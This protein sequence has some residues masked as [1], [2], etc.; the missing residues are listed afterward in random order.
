MN[1]SS[2]SADKLLTTLRSLPP[3]ELYYIAYS[4]G[5]DSHVLLHALLSIKSELNADIHALHV[6]HG[7]N[8]SANSWATHCEKTCNDLEINFTLLKIDESCPRGESR[9]A[10]ARRLRYQLLIARMSAGDVLLTAHHQD[11][12][13]ETLL[14]QMS[15]GAG[16]KGL[17][18]M[19]MLKKQDSVWHARP[20]LG[21]GRQHLMDYARLH[22]LQWIEDD[23][24]SDTSYDR[25][26]FRKEII[27]KLQQR[28]PSVTATLARAASHQVEAMMLLEE[29]AAADLLGCGDEAA[30]RLKLGPLLLLSPARQANVIRYWLRSLKLPVPDSRVMQEILNKFL[31][32]RADASPLISWPGIE[33]RR[34]QQHLYACGPLRSH[35]GQNNLN[36]HLESPCRCSD[37]VL[38]A[39]MG[40]G[41]GI[42]VSVCPDKQ[43]QVGYRQGGEKIRLT[44]K[45]ST[46]E[47]KKLFQ[48]A[49]IPPWLRDRVPLLYKDDVLIA[50]AGLWIAAE[51]CTGKDESAWQIHWTGLDSLKVSMQYLHDD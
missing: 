44:K 11:D 34:Y 8:V 43:L 45:G 23:S 29:M 4:G 20:L 12:Q 7:L 15:R 19:P 49:G 48:Q 1:D 14:L 40:Q 2:F 41:A 10:W 37:G 46:Q 25:N 26:F 32:A 13:A 39:K 18:A 6:N 16:V 42:K 21:A 27:P 47:L 24:N 22:G 28:W 33:L 35:Q 9:E 51:A 30:A 3:F 17:A 5:L 38:S 50:V 31:P 36:W